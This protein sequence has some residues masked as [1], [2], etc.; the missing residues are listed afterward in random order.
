MSEEEVKITIQH[1]PKDLHK[2]MQGQALLEE[3][4]LYT[5]WIRLA[6][7]WRKSL[8]REVEVNKQRM[9]W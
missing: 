9:G 4:P 5:L 7:E 2:F 3:V 1:V 6:E 8:E